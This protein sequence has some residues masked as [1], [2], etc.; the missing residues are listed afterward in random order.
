MT[1]PHIKNNTDEDHPD[2]IVASSS[3]KLDNPDQASQPL[4]K[5]AQK[6]AAKAARIA[7]NKLER[8]AREKAAKKEKKRELASKRVA[9]EIL[10]DEDDDGQG[11]RK[12]LKGEQ[13]VEPFGARVV[14]DLGFDEMMTEKVLN[15]IRHI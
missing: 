2:D 13:S 4:S 8:R 9:G 5:S 15:L 3:T 1:M 11:K 10:G 6:K 12:K 14:V 7:A